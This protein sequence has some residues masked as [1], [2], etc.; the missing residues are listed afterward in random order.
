MEDEID[1]RPYLLAIVSRWRWIVLAAIIAAATAS[2]ISLLGPPTYTAAATVFLRATHSQVTLDPRF[3]TNEAIDAG[4]HRQGLLAL[5]KSNLIQA[6]IPPETLKSLVSAGDVVGELASRIGVKANG[7]LLIISA[8][9]PTPEQARTLVD[10]WAAGFVKYANALQGNANVSTNGTE[11]V[12]TATERY[13]TAERAYEQFLGT[14]HLYE[15]QQ[16]IAA[17]SGVITNTQKAMQ[18][19]HTAALAN[20]QRLESVLRDAEALRGEI[21]AGSSIGPS[22]KLATLLLRARASG[23]E[24]LAVQLQVGQFGTP[25]NG[26]GVTVANLDAFIRALQMQIADNRTNATKIA[27]ALT[28][29][30]LGSDS[31]VAPEQQAAYYTQL[32]DLRRQLEAEEGK[33]RLLEQERDVAIEGL[34]VVRRKLA[35]EQVAAVR[36]DAEVQLAGKAQLPD[37]PSSRHTLLLGVAGGLAGAL[38][39]I[40]GVLLVE[41]GAIAIPRSERRAPDRRANSPSSS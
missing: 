35:E 30:T 37:R 2:A 34:Q 40:V 33:R 1:L 41:L 39:A 3:V 36:P 19:S 28:S 17:T 8:D 25:G 12:H 11:Q 27:A 38:I 6:Q 9:A 15:L 20:V 23:G 7:D 26:E 14:S 24:R 13:A 21:A 4:A 5:A 16:R 22:Q 18:T 29:N 10:A 32:L 31:G